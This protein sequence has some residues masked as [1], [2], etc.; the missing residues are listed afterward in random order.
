M[1]KV[2]TNRVQVLQRYHQCESNDVRTHEPYRWNTAV[3]TNEEE[4][5]NCEVFY[6]NGDEIFSEKPSSEYASNFA[7]EDGYDANYYYLCEFQMRDFGLREKVS[8][9]FCSDEVGHF[10][11]ELDK[12]KYWAGI[13]NPLLAEHNEPFFINKESNGTF[14]LNTGYE[15]LNELRYRGYN[16]SV[17]A[18]V[19]DYTD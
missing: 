2:L 14:H 8:T 11:V 12:A 1:T 3:A 7:A 17:W 9:D 6:Q 18:I 5:L 13:E 10:Y 15:L 16:G 19:S 4:Y